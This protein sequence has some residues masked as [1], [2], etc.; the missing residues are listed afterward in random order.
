MAAPIYGRLAFF[1]SAGKTPM[2]IKFLLLGGGFWVFLQGGCGSANFIFMGV[3]FFLRA[4][5]RESGSSRKVLT[6]ALAQV[7]AN[8]L[9]LATAKTVAWKAIINSPSWEWLVD[10]EHVVTYGKVLSAP[11]SRHR[12]PLAIFT[13]D[14]GIARNS[15]AR[16]IFTGNAKLPTTTAQ[17]QNQALGRQ[18]YGRYPNPEKHRKI[19]STIAFAGLAKFWALR[20]W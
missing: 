5:D 9:V 18:V 1:G 14:E 10:C 8:L 7:L 20:W 4:Q 6:R 17:E 15:A 19:I 12:R 2:P 11:K 16:T 3:G 13:A